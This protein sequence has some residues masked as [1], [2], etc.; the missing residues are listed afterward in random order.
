MRST[1]RKDAVFQ[2]QPVWGLAALLCLQFLT[3]EGQAPAPS[4]SDW[5]IGAHLSTKTT[6]EFANPPQGSVPLSEREDPPGCE[7]SY[8]HLVS[9]HGARYPTASKMKKMAALSRIF[10]GVPASKE[11]PW[12]HSWQYPFSMRQDA[13]GQLHPRGEQEMRNLAARFRARFPFLMNATYLP[14]VFPFA[15]TQ[16]PRTA[17]SAAAFAQG[18]FPCEKGGGAGTQEG[19]K[20]PG[21]PAGPAPAP[22]PQGPPGP[23]SCPAACLPQPVALLMSPADNDTLF[24]FFDAC[25]AYQDF[26][27]RAEDA[28]E[29]WLKEQYKD[30]VAGMEVRLGLPRGSLSKSD[31]KTMWD[32]CGVEAGLLDNPALVCSLFPPQ[33]AEVMEYL[34]DVA[35]L[36]SKGHAAC[37]SYSMAG[38][39]LRSLGQALSTAAGQAASEG[40]ARAALNFA[41]AETLIPLA[42]LLGLFGSPGP[43]DIPPNRTDIDAGKL[44]P[45]PPADREWK[46]SRVAPFSGNIAVIMYTCQARPLRAPLNVP[47]HQNAAQEPVHIVRAAYNEHVIGL[48]GC[49]G[50][51]DC[52]LEVFL[53]EVVKVAGD[54][55]R[56]RTD[57]GTVEGTQPVFEGDV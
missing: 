29:P 4:P 52:P 31:L 7:A 2:S 11:Y 28:M 6:Y 1:P 30:L 41:H 3:C 17:A 16:V 40:R 53:E 48:P 43:C 46:G 55:D 18:L 54:L 14:P 42:A 9:R 38:P 35:T 34:E 19:S 13:A 20:D 21:S 5:N 12:I 8:L 50:V 49:A 22:R 44:L 47:L 23:G 37:E 33:D 56:F 15:S 57:C 26:A 24:R 32:M 36:G 45:P 27:K 25:P 10:E 51:S 39:L